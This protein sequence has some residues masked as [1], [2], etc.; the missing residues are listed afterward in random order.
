MKE[1]VTAYTLARLPIG[2][3]F[4]GHGFIRIPKLQQFR[5]GMMKGFSETAFP[6]A[7]VQPFAYLLPFLELLLGITLIIGFKMKA[8]AAVGVLLIC[9]LIFGMSFQEN[10]NAIFIEMMYGAYL[11]AL[12]LFADYNTLLFTKKK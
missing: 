12:Y 4:L 9:T 6:L 10:W 11:A 2:F 8:S 1:K 7:I 5:E 3:S